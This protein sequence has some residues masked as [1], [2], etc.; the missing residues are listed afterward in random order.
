MKELECQWDSRKSFYRKAMYEENRGI[1]TLYSYGTKIISVKGNK[2][3]K[4][5][6]GYTRNTQRHI[7]EFIYQQ[8]G[9]VMEK[10][11]YENLP[12]DKWVDLKK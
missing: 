7:K 12:Y 4:L 10:K 8:L 11:D 9:V 3:K 1:T 2:V 5:W 6:E